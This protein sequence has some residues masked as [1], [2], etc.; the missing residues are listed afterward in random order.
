MWF[1]HSKIGAKRFDFR[2]RDVKRLKHNI[3]W[4]N[5]SKDGNGEITDGAVNMANH[6]TGGK[7][8][9]GV[10]QKIISMMP[11][12]SLYIEPFLGNG[13]VMRYKKAASN[14][15]GID[16]D[17]QVINNLWTGKEIPNLQLTCGNALYW[18]KQTFWLTKNPKDTLIYCD[19]P[20]LMETRRSQRQLYRCDM[21]DEDSHYELLSILIDLP[22][23]VMISCYPNELYDNMLHANG[24]RYELVK[25]PTRG[26][27]WIDEY[28]F[29]NFPKPLE[30]HDYTFLGET[31][32]ERDN[33]KRQRQRWINNF[34]KMDEQKRYAILSALEE[35]RSGN[36]TNADARSIV[37]VPLFEI[38]N[39]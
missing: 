30:L 31:Y 19:P 25:C 10:Y 26:G 38:P 29:M 39:D 37:E 36:G 4:L 35:I 14:S 22:C 5:S 17:D 8:G 1:S 18:L 33:I 7:G 24:W 11:P 3:L 6:Y 27:Q 12:H 32:R 34:A 15:W 20:Y 2:K 13:S 23:L 28:V 21:A 9:S 16:D